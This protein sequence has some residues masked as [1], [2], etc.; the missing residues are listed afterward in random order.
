MRPSYTGFA[1]SCE[2][3]DR[4]LKCGEKAPERKEHYNKRRNDLNVLACIHC[5]LDNVVVVD[6][7]AS[8]AVQ[9]SGSSIAM[10]ALAILNL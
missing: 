6:K 4:Q 3:N 10:D 2:I 5:M 7:V 8:S 9:N 1:I